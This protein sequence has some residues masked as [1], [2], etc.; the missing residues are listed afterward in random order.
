MGGGDA[1][2]VDDGLERG[3]VAR[4]GQRQRQRDLRRVAAFVREQVADERIERRRQRECPAF[5]VIAREPQQCVGERALRSVPAV[6]R[7]GVVRR[8][9]D[10]VVVAI[11]ERHFHRR[12]EAAQQRW[13]R[14]R[15]NAGELEGLARVADVQHASRRPRRSLAGERE[16]EIAAV[17][18]EQADRQRNVERRLHRLSR[19]GRRALRDVE[20]IRPRFRVVAAGDADHRRAR[21]RSTSGGTAQDRRPT[22]PASPARSH[23]RSPPGRRAAR[24]RDR[25]RGGTRRRRAACAASGSTRRLFRRRWPCRSC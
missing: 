16:R 1:I 8:E 21:L 18:A 20:R 23:R 2:D 22:H 12:R 15:R 11:V 17:P 5:A 6:H 4:I 9:E 14:S 7:V 3:D 19:R 24:S 13:H 10:D 25:C